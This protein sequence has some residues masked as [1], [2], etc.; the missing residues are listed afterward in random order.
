MGPKKIKGLS[1][2]HSLVQL[3]KDPTPIKKED[4]KDLLIPPSYKSHTY[5]M[6][7]WIEYDKE[8]SSVDVL[9]TS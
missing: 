4:V 1:Y 6:K 5:T 7:L 2:L 3:E 8:Q 9:L